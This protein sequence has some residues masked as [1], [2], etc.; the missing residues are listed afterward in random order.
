MLQSHFQALSLNRL[1]E[2]KSSASWNFTELINLKNI[3]L[4]PVPQREYDC[5][6]YVA[7]VRVVL[8]IH[9]NKDVTIVAILAVGMGTFLCPSPQQ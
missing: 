5:L 3:G 1:L 8:L 4:L 2:V 9:G 7:P 6:K